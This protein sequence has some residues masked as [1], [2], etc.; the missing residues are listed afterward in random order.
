MLEAK[1]EA[2]KKGG[3]LNS[4]PKNVIV[5]GA[6]HAHKH[7]LKDLEVFEDAEITLKGVPVVTFEDGG[8]VTQH[9]EV[10]REEIILHLELTEK[11]E[12]LAKEGTDEAKIEAGKLLVKEILSNTKDSD[13]KLLK[14]TE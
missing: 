10:E 3:V 11:L 1:I 2:F 8:A 4:P 5:S 7:N 6:L 9:A 13:T 14:K 12:A